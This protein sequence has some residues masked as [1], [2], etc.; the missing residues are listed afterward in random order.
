MRTRVLVCGPSGCGKTAWIHGYRV[1]GDRHMLWQFMPCC[2]GGPGFTTIYVESNR[3]RTYWTQ[4]VL[5][6]EDYFD[7]VIYWPDVGAAPQLY[8]K[9]NDPVQW[10]QFWQPDSSLL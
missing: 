1:P 4:E 9:A 7:Q 10:E 8:V 5:D 3:D 2:F 6:A